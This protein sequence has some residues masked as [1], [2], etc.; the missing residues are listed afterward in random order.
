MFHPDS[1][2]YDVN[3]RDIMS[4]FSKKNA[5]RTGYEFKLENPI[6]DLYAAPDKVMDI[7]PVVNSDFVYDYVVQNPNKTAWAVSFS[8]PNRETSPGTNIQYQLWFNA[9]ATANGSDIFGRTVLSFVRGLD[10]AIISV[11]NDPSATITANIDVK[12]KDWPIIPP[13]TVSDS[14]VQQLGPVFFFCSEM[15]IFINVLNSIVT[16]KELKLRHGMEVMGLKPGV[17]WLSHFLSNTLLVFFNGLFSTIWGYIYGFQ[18]YSNANFF[19]LFITFFLFGEAMVMFAFFITTLVRRSRVAILIGI[20]IFIIGLLFESFV[21]SSGQLGYIWWSRGTIEDYWAIIMCFLPFFNFGHMFLDITTLTT[22]ILDTLTDT[23]IPGP[24]FEWNSLYTPINQ[25][26]L[27]MYGSAGYPDV[28]APVYAWYWLLINVAFYGVLTWYL[29]NVIPNEYGYYRPAWFFLTPSYWGFEK[30]EQTDLSAWQIEN[31][32]YSMEPEAKEDSDVVEE[33]KRALDRN[34][35]PPLKIVNLR[36]VYANG[37]FKR[38]TKVAVRNSCFTVEQGK[39]LALLGQNGAGKIF[40]NI[41]KS[42]TISMLSGLTP[43]TAGDALIFNRSVRYSIMAIRRIM[44]ICPQHDILFDD[45]TAREHI[46]L[47]AGLKGVPKEQWEPLI[48]SR[49]EMVKLMSV[50]DVRAGTYS[51]GMKRRLSLVISTIGD[52]KIIF[53]DEPTTGMDPVNRRHV[54]S[55]IEK[56]KKE[57]V[58]I[59]TT[60]SMEEAD[61]VINYPYLARGSSMCHVQ[62]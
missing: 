33:R 14:I 55:F 3:Y 16:E 35:F 10:E 19:V 52:P 50:A 9:T 31:E 32:K 24:G 60:H 36:K 61:V 7:V 6:T 62:G 49:L 59:L 5:E 42:T 53:L 29:D 4:V 37:I 11:L 54:W 28:P 47:Y 56:F 34:Y 38:E 12:M 2:E 17:Y 43:S 44:G 25:S 30:S 40:C 1:T 45:L 51:G 22:G 20:F 58:I 41:G 8:Q 46:Q 21:F 39:L 57:R 23:Y 18:A 13:K 26:S 27:P 15:L 48:E